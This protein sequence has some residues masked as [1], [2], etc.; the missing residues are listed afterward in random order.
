MAR[1]SCR[2]PGHSPG[3]REMPRAVS[4]T[5]MGYG[6]L[7]DAANR[8]SLGPARPRTAQAGHTQPHRR[9]G[10]LPS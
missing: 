3:S 1:A 6:S 2:A 7:P 8:R 10:E 9:L 5:P 4:R